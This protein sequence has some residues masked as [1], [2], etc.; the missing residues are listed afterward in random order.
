MQEKGAAC[1]PLLGQQQSQG[2]D[3][4]TAAPALPSAVPLPDLS[5]PGNELLKAKP[6]VRSFKCLQNSFYFKATQLA[7]IS[8]QIG[9]LLAALNSKKHESIAKNT[10][11]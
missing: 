1:G 8:S 9:C 4:S 2:W 3:E 6:K 10:T 7:A 5:E 11:S